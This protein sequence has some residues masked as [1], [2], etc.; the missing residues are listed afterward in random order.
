MTLIH[1]PVS[2]SGYQ[3]E[4]Q[5]KDDRIQAVSYQS[6]AFSK[7]RYTRQKLTISLSKP[8]RED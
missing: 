8:T 1:T 7:C 4:K 3:D 6:T 5:A 2:S